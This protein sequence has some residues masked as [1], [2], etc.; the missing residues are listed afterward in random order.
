[1]NKFITFL[2]KVFTREVKKEEKEFFSTCYKPNSY[3]G[4]MC[5][6]NCKNL[7][8]LL[9]HPMNTGDFK[10][11][12]SSQIAYVCTAQFEDGS[13]RGTVTAQT[14]PHGMCEYYELDP[15]K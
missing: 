11:S 3:N 7:K 10:G 4:K 1:M 12:M 15:D 9:R 13:N 2:K 6:C 8:A 14:S 5:C